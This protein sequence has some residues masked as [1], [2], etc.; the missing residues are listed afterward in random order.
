[1]ISDSKWKEK[2]NIKQHTKNGNLMN[3]LNS[4][5]IGVHLVRIT[6]GRVELLCPTKSLELVGEKGLYGHKQC[7]VACAI[8]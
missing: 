1:V 3:I 2:I 7:E 5:C 6:M 8:S 4:D